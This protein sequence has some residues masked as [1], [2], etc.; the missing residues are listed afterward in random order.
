MQVLDTVVACCIDAHSRAGRLGSHNHPVES[1]HA[2]YAYFCMG[3][4]DA[5]VRHLGWNHKSEYVRPPAIGWFDDFPVYAYNASTCVN[6]MLLRAV[7]LDKLL[8]TGTVHALR[9]HAP[10]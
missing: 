4:H 1:I 10:C 2:W 7:E 5:S 9:V 3:L 6:R 8:Q